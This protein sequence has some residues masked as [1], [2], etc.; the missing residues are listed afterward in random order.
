MKQIETRSIEEMKNFL[1]Q[2]GFD[3]YKGFD[4]PLYFHPKRGEIQG[5]QRGYNP[6]LKGYEL[7][8]LTIQ[9]DGSAPRNYQSVSKSDIFQVPLIVGSY[10]STDSG[11]LIV[12]D[13]MDKDSKELI[14]PARLNLNDIIGYETLKRIE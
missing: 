4:T 13:L 5:E 9:E 2:F 8:L 12:S 6:H 10:R 7:A 14:H 1:G 11:L 3:S